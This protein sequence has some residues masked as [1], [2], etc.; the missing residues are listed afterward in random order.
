MT[1]STLLSNSYSSPLEYRFL[2]SNETGNI[3]IRSFKIQ[4]IGLVSLQIKKT[5]NL[6]RCDNMVS[7]HTIKFR[8]SDYE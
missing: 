5:K 1:C 3:R 6:K 4:L 2:Y 8:N 7:H